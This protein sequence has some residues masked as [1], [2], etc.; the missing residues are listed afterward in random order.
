MVGTPKLI[1]AA[2]ADAALGNWVDRYAPA[3]TRPF[4]RLARLDRPIGAWL[5]FWPCAWS[6]ALA[7]RSAGE[8]FPNIW[9]LVLFAIGATV[10]RGAGCTYNDIL[11]RNIDAQVARTRSRPLPSGQIT[12]RAAASFMV[13]L[14]LAGFLV[15]LQ[16]NAFAIVLGIASLLPVAIYPL[17]KRITHWPQ[18][19]LGLSFGWGALMGWAAVFGGLD[20]PAVLLYAATIS[21]IIGYDTIYAHQD[22]E[23]DA[24]IGL[25]STALRFGP[26]TPYWLT[27]FYGLTWM[28]LLA[29]GLMVGSGVIMH[30]AL[31]L[32]AL[33]FTWQITTLDIG[34]AQNCL[35]RFR[36]NSVVG[37]VVFAGMV[38]DG[39]LA[40]ST[41]A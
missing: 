10:M 13:A 32:V 1:D 11:D 6:A 19:V 8:A 21:W 14:A 33:Q 38:L 16:F 27:G 2:V 17:M 3:V 37:M 28:L 29:A 39:A 22:K 40:A 34:D 18:A 23:D 31:A 4:L 24:L 30:T 15:L 12:T 7:A 36:S 5:L 9:H 20:W 26:Q 25:G 41:A 35:T